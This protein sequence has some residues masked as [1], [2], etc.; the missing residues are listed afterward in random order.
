[1]LPYDLL[2][3]IT[4]YLDFDDIHALHLTCKSLYYSTTTRPVYRK[5]AGDLLRRCRPL[6]LRGFQR[7]MDLSS[8]QLI[9]SVNKAHHYERAWRARGPRP[10]ATN[11]SGKIDRMNMNHYLHA[12][13]NSPQ[14]TPWF[15]ILQS[16]PEEEVDWLSPI[17]SSYILCATKSGKVVCWDIKTDRCLAD[18]IP[19]ER[20][21]LWKCRVEF[22]EKMVYFTMAKVLKGSY[23]DTRLMHFSLMRLSF[24]DTER[25]NDH[26]EGSTSTTP[27]P[28]FSHVTSF[29]TTGVVMNIFLLDPAAR[30]LSAFIWVSESNTIGLFVL[31]DWDRDEYVF[32]DTGIE[33]VISSNW[34][35][36]L[37]AN[38]I[39][40][41][42]EDSDAAFQHFY[43]L[44]HL[45]EHVQ[46]AHGGLSNCVPIH[47]GR[48]R[49]WESIVKKFKFPRHLG[50]PRTSS[51]RRMRTSTGVHTHDWDLEPDEEEQEDDFTQDEDLFGTRANSGDVTSSGS[52]Q[53]QSASVST[54][55]LTSIPGD[56]SFSSSA[57]AS[58][59]TLVSG[60]SR[61]SQPERIVVPD[62]AS[63]QRGDVEMDTMASSQS[64]LSRE[65]AQPEPPVSNPF[66][67][68]PWYPESAHFVR[69]W[70][71]SLP[72]LTNN[73]AHYKRRENDDDDASDSG[74]YSNSNSS[75]RGSPARSQQQNIPVSVP[76]GVPRVSCTVVLLASHDPTTHRTKFVLMQHY[77]RVPMRGADWVELRARG[78]GRM[79]IGV[80]NGGGGGD[81]GNPGGGGDGGGGG[82]GGGANAAGTLSNSAYSINGTMVNRPGPGDDSDSSSDEGNVQG[83]GNGLGN[84]H[85]TQNNAPLELYMVDEPPEGS[86][87]VDAYRS[88]G[89][90]VG[91]GSSPTSSPGGTKSANRKLRAT[92]EDPM[93]IW[94]VAEPFEVVCVLDSAQ[95][96]DE[97]EDGGGNEEGTQERPR[98]L[99]AV[100][101]GHA[102]WVE[103]VPD[104]ERNSEGDELGVE[105]PTRHEHDDDD[106]DHGY[107]RH[108]RVHNGIGL[109]TDPK[110]LRFVSF[111]PYSDTD[112]G[113]YGDMGEVRTLEIPPELNLDHVETINVD[114]SQGAVILS[115][116]DGKIFILCYE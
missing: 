70:W 74:S 102:V 38:N 67:F 104:E 13:P 100:D 98:P 57:S 110:R 17:T 46:I 54:S 11:G 61:T 37:Y 5:L 113:G 114:Q 1:M 101:F 36:I 79:S 7:V 90:D 50:P 105:R 95:S 89:G 43:P 86:V 21:E 107:V 42:C 28:S 60:P 80:G 32:V 73:H 33:C 103:Y 69:Q 87:V 91:Y 84:S 48:V 8:E 85:T 55:G 83:Q 53:S 59:S 26:R 19:G 25:N 16:P 81:N 92:E 109:E 64:S 72:S 111:P 77:F 22:D 82:G 31:L 9:V 6:P 35:C 65:D 29:R 68:P 15:R 45:E 75:S 63:D 66:P 93:D 52:A 44:T 116:K 18:W 76:G 14:S 41:H 23:D 88:D 27:P 4:A 56:A 115:V 108:E 24:V 96:D 40:I 12:L 71:P 97:D 3:N 34:S 112:S 106:E 2:L 10:V 58:T 47:S 62:V 99:I 51:S 78:R 20:W 49:P 94:Y 39:V 30:L